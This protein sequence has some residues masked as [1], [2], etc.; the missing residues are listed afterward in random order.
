MMKVMIAF[1]A[2]N[3]DTEQFKGYVAPGEETHL[4]QAH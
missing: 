3:H 4:Q 2:V 1:H